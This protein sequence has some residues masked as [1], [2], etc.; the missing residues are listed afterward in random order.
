MASLPTKCC[1]EPNM[2][3]A[4]LV[5][6]LAAGCSKLPYLAS[7][8]PPPPPVEPAPIGPP[9]PIPFPPPVGPISGQPLDVS[10]SEPPTPPIGLPCIMLRGLPPQTGPSG[11]IIIPCIISACISSSRRGPL[12]APRWRP[13]RPWLNKG[14]LANWFGS[15]RAGLCM[16]GG[17]PGVNSKEE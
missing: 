15:G 9:R 6:P 8:P 3:S 7:I 10:E 2:D 17:I 11:P 5:P 1:A 12:G 4:L 16:L 13:A 14:E